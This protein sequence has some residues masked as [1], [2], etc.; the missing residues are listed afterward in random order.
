MRQRQKTATRL[1]PLWLSAPK[2]NQPREEVQSHLVNTRRTPSTKRTTKQFAS[3]S[4]LQQEYCAELS[5]A[6]SRR[7]TAE[8][9]CCGI[10][11]E[12]TLYYVYHGIREPATGERD[13]LKRDLS[14]MQ[15]YADNVKSTFDAAHGDLQSYRMRVKEINT[16]KS[17]LRKETLRLT[18]ENAQLQSQ[19]NHIRAEKQRMTSAMAHLRRRYDDQRQRTQDLESIEDRY[20]NL[21]EAHA[22]L[23]EIHDR[24]CNDLGDALEHL[25][26]VQSIL[27]STKQDEYN[28]TE[29]RFCECGRASR[30][31]AKVSVEVT[32]ETSSRSVLFGNI[33]C[34]EIGKGLEGSGT[35]RDSLPPT[36]DRPI[37][38]TT[39]APK[40]VAWLSIPT[41]NLVQ[42]LKLRERTL[43]VN[44]T[45]YLL[46]AVGT[47]I[48]YHMAKAVSQ[49]QTER[50]SNLKPVEYEEGYAFT[51]GPFNSAWEEVQA[52]AS[53]R[54]VW[55]IL[56]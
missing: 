43:S 1:I 50:T 40:I 8:Q 15:R 45:V 47:V 52:I 24:T 17:C 35:T 25:Q 26:R 39:H 11:G 16:E 37:E 44:H 34:V 2:T 55:E 22:D 9:L 4:A 6:I 31:T 5:D 13:R 33:E 46:L 53:E 49:K 36:T 14:S 28:S 3:K 27:E 12:F 10:R 30:Q 48:V 18:N 42:Q 7:E 38:Q 19:L 20:L 51:C 41:S 29:R 56:Q 23:Q 54:V 32:T 21:D